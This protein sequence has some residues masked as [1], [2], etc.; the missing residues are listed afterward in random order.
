MNVHV[1]VTRDQSDYYD[2]GEAI[3]VESGLTLT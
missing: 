2:T 1:R 3:D